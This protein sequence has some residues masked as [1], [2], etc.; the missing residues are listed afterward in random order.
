MEHWKVIPT[1]PRYEVSDRGRVRNRDTERIMRTKLNQYGVVGV[2]LMRDG[3]QHH[4]SV[5][6]LVA[7]AFLPMEKEAFDTPINLDG[8]RFNNDVENLVWRPRWFAIQYNRQFK[9]RY[10]RPIT[11]AIVDINTNKVFFDSFAVATTFGLLERDVVLSIFNR[12]YVWPTYQQFAIS[13]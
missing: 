1:F 2:G 11:R 3:E 5:P 9:V 6:K 7:M 10:D 8:N 13:E 4:R 12:T